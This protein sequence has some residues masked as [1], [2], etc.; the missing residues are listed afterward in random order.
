MVLGLVEL[1]GAKGIGGAQLVWSWGCP[2]YAQKQAKNAFF[3]FFACFWAYVG[4]P[5]HHIGLATSMPFRSINTTNPRTNPWNFLEQILRIGGF[6][7]L[8][9]LCRPFWIK[10]LL[11]SCRFPYESMFVCKEEVTGLIQKPI[12]Y[13]QKVK[14]QLRIH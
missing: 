14:Y 10:F 8:S 1:I 13:C 2:T 3:V 9:Y 7:D 12:F 6:E 4:Q 11:N 5:H